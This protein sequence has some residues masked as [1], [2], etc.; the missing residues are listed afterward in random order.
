[1][2]L[3]L[4]AGLE[5]T[6][7]LARVNDLS[8]RLVSSGGLKA[9]PMRLPDWS[10]WLAAVVAAYG[11]TAALLLVSG[12]ARRILLWL[13]ALLL[14][15]AWAP[16]LGLAAR[17]PAVAA[18]WVAVAWSGACAVF[19]ASRHRMPCDEIPRDDT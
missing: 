1:M 6:G 13:T 19:Y 3:V 4:A 14:M 12:G 16:V 15:T 10:M 9:F 17:Y 2:S 7:G 5:L 18:P 8:A 11:M